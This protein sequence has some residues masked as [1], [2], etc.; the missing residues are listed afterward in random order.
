[1]LEPLLFH[2]VLCWPCGTDWKSWS[3]SSPLCWWFSDLDLRRPRDVDRLAASISGFSACVYSQVYALVSSSAQRFK[4]DALWFSTGP[5]LHRLLSSGVLIDPIIWS[6]MR[7]QVRVTPPDVLPRFAILDR[8]TEFYRR[9]CCRR[10]WLHW[11]LGD[12]NTETACRII[13][14]CGLTSVFRTFPPVWSSTWG[15]F[16]Q[17]SGA[18]IQLFL[19]GLCSRTY[20]FQCSDH[21]ASF[22]IRYR[23]AVF[24]ADVHKSRR[25]SSASS[26]AI[27]LGSCCYWMFWL[28][29]AVVHLMC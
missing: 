26:T 8:C 25:R 1:M 21:V 19:L 17:I 28:Q 15:C 10:L 22:F 5:R 3:V 13:L 16:D 20:R 14:S 12:S 7:S 11:A 29:S 23:S 9:T 2:H 18:L 4:I 24:A 27:N 6:T